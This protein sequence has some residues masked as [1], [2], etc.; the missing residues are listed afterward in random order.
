MA[1]DQEIEN[2]V[3]RFSVDNGAEY[4]RLMQEAAK[5][6]DEYGTTVAKA[7]KLVQSLVE[8][9]GTITKMSAGVV[10]ALGADVIL[11]SLDDI[12]EWI[13]TGARGSRG[14]A[15]DL[16]EAAE[17]AGRTVE[18]MGALKRYSDMT[19]ISMKKLIE[20]MKTMPD[21]VKEWANQQ[22]KL[23]QFMSTGEAKTAKKFNVALDSM[24]RTIQRIGQMLSHA[25]FPVLTEWA[26]RMEKM[27]QVVLNF[28]TNNQELIRT[29]FSWAAKIAGVG[30]SIG[31]ASKLIGQFSG[32]LS[33]LSGVFGI[34]TAAVSTFMGILLSVPV[35]L[36]ALGAAAAVVASAFVN[37]KE[38]IPAALGAVK[39]G[40]WSLVDVGREVFST[41]LGDGIDAFEAI[42]NAFKAGDLAAAAK[43]AW[44]MVVLEGAR[45]AA[46]IMGIWD[47]IK[48]YTL[49]VWE[50]I[51]DAFMTL[52]EDKP[53]WLAQLWE[54]PLGTI[55]RLWKTTFNNIKLY[56][57]QSIIQAID[58]IKPIIAGMLPNLPKA[59]TNMV[60]ALAGLSGTD[61]ALGKGKTKLQEWEEELKRSADEIARA[62]ELAA[63]SVTELTEE[64]KAALQETR[65]AEADA[66]A[67]K[68]RI[69]AE[70]RS[71][72]WQDYVTESKK[73]FDEARAAAL[74]LKPKGGTQEDKLF[75][76][77]SEKAKHKPGSVSAEAQTVE[78]YTADFKKML[79]D[80]LYFAA[81][82][83]KEGKGP[84]VSPEVEEKG[85]EGKLDSVN[86]TL[87]DIFNMVRDAL[88]KP[89]TS[90]IE[91][92]GLVPGISAFGN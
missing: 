52:W 19:G 83:E 16:S 3:T 89:K 47:T 17:E 85:V 32:V 61:E 21:S 79:S 12:K 31:I 27:A 84:W 57:V 37:W 2:L 43:V 74:G 42:S 49:R 5:A 80:Q 48:D 67:E 6:V 71:K 39:S 64:E 69:E 20:N 35:P 65:K 1:N 33:L 34:V 18:E 51:V 76:D 23:N 53:N 15:K 26:N 54:D 40:F 8:V 56:I 90:T 41:L 24:M 55:E 62:N 50:G 58:V 66:A 7:T 44:T 14:M 92:A 91:G 73:A 63:K 87:T 22:N 78:A 68:R 13:T 72:Q 59:V 75:E 77:M 25:I 29:I 45:G 38:V 82:A 36:L 60:P 88:A 4:R 30:V 28:V 9:G 11:S 10:G 81:T 46:A 70:Q 86:L